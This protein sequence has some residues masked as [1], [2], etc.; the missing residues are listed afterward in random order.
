MDR[1]SVRMATQ[2][3]KDSALN[4][5]PADFAHRPLKNPV[6]NY[7]SADCNNCEPSARRKYKAFSAVTLPSIRET[8]VHPRARA[9][10]GSV[11]LFDC[12]KDHG[13]VV[14]AMTDDQG[15]DAFVRE[16]K[17]LH[18]GIRQLSVPYYDNEEAKE[19]SGVE[20]I[21]SIDCEGVDTSELRYKKPI[22]SGLDMADF[23]QHSGASS[24]PE[25]L[26]RE[27]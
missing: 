6:C 17:S 9:N 26:G 21:Q 24:S 20:M 27:R 19:P 11:G 3:T 4:T 5:L 18:F 23:Y 2:K 13:R 22:T 7:C 12:S 25:R 8:R 15:G 1:Q 10:L 14:N 16:K